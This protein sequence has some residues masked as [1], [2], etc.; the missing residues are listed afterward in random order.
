MKYTQNL[1]LNKQILL[2]TIPIVVILYAASGFAVYQLSKKRV[3][4]A[5]QRE[6]EVYLNKMS[7]TVQL[8]EDQTGH[9]YS[10]ADYLLL[11]PFFNQNGYYKT[12]YPFVFDNSGQYI[13]H[14]FKES[15]RIPGILLQDIKKS[16]SKEGISVLH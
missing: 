6:M 15:Q 12:D 11:K 1:N 13:I 2:F 8:V 4:N 3:L 16:H 5:A 10:N 7:E 9:G 14:A